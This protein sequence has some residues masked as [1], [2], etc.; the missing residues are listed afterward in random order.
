MLICKEIS[1]IRGIRAIKF[2]FQFRRPFF[3][4]K[5][6]NNLVASFT[7]AEKSVCTVDSSVLDNQSI[8]IMDSI[9]AD[10]CSCFRID[11]VKVPITGR[12][13]SR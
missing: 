9:V 3:A 6:Q 11:V 8:V 10:G 1:G 5:R 13:G 4:V 2:E 12:F 7:V